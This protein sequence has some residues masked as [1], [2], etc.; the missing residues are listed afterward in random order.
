VQW[1]I[2]ARLNTTLTVAG[3]GRD[4]FCANNNLFLLLSVVHTNI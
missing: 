3:R 4:L 2:D 1:K